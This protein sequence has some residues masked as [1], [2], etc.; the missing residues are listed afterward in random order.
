MATAIRFSVE[1]LNNVT[2]LCEQRTI[3]VEISFFNV[4]VYW[5]SAL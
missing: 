3:R 1:I 4:V 5:S 2:E